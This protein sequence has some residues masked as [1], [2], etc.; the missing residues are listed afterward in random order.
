MATQDTENVRRRDTL[1]VANSPDITDDEESGD[2][3]QAGDVPRE[4][5]RH[6]TP[7]NNTEGEDD[8]IR[9]LREELARVT[10]QWEAERIRSQELER[11]LNRPMNRLEIDRQEV[12]EGAG[13]VPRRNRQNAHMPNVNGNRVGDA[14]GQQQEAIR[15]ETMNAI[16]FALKM[17][18]VYFDGDSK[19]VNPRWFVEQVEEI[20]GRREIGDNAMKTIFRGQ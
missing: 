11:R 14:G 8:N 3:I 9:R 20:A 7:L 16:S 2:R 15:R 13:A 5:P 1:F 10:T 19:K 12:G 18:D 6:S 17:S 4:V